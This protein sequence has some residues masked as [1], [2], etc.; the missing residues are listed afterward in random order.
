MS[1]SL[2]VNVAHEVVHHRAETV[3]VLAAADLVHLIPVRLLL[4]GKQRCSC[5][6]PL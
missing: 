5:R 2:A 4:D 1:S 6:S 3:D